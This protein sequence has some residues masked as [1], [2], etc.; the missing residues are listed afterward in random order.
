M[1]I[2]DMSMFKQIL[3]RE[4]FYVIL[5]DRKILRDQENDIRLIWSKEAHA[6]SYLEESNITQFDK[7]MELD[8]DRFVTYEMDEILDEGDQ[9]IVDRF[10]SNKGIEVEAI[11]FIEEIMSELDDI[12][13]EEFAEDI[14]KEKYVYGL[15]VKGQKQFIIISEEDESLP[16]MMTVWSTRKL[17]EKIRREDFDEYEI[18]EIETDVFEEWLVDLKQEDIA[19]GVNL[20]SGMIGTVTDPKAV[21]NAMPC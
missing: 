6:Q 11:P 19:L 3:A 14:C 8:L 9:F 5:I 21:L 20:K 4:K 17:A 2:Q 13:I 16:D 7:I 10:E 12:R 18:I 15:T 1:A